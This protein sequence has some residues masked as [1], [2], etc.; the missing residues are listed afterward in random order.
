ML[1]NYEK[2]WVVS[3]PLRTP[4]R[5]ITHREA[6]IFEGERF[7][8]WSP[9]LEYEDTEAATWLNAAM[10]FANEPLPKLNRTHIKT[11][12]T[13]PAVKPDEIQKTLEP[14]GSFETVKIKVAQKGENL[15]QDLERVREVHSLYPTAKLRLD[16]NGGYSLEQAKSLAERLDGLPIEYLE[17]P[18]ATISELAEYRAWLQGQYLIAADESVRKTLDPEAVIAAGAADILMLKVQPL[19]GINDALKVAS[20]GVDV[21]VSSALETSLGI[22]QGAYLAAALPELKYDCGLGTLNLLAGDIAKQSMVPKDSVLEVR[23][24]EIDHALL[25]QYAAAADRVDWWQQRFER[26]LVLL[27]S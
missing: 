18:L 7:A 22:A 26:C 12:A 13:L 15:E 10:S 16:A 21:V 3:I 5:G 17:Q 1:A 19:G 8:E 11:N 4:F 14:Y 25:E 20:H 27:E 9:F 23:M 6:V 2:L 24:P